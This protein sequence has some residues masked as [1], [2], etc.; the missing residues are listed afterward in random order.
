MVI[1]MTIKIYIEVFDTFQSY[2]IMAF[3]VKSLKMKDT[4]LL[5][6]NLKKIQ[7]NIIFFNI[8]FNI[9]FMINIKIF[10]WNYFIFKIV[11]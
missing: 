5:L 3:L 10:K 8:F 9:F 2:T 6:I 4:K 1:T 7:F 11:C